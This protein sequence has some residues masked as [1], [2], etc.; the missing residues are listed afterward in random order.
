MAVKTGCKTVDLT[1]LAER[2][3]VQGAALGAN[4]SRDPLGRNEWAC[5]CDRC[6]APYAQTDPIKTPPPAAHAV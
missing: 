5:C 1:A 2:T 3:E 4:L 6:C